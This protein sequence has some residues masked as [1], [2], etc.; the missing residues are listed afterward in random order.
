MAVILHEDHQD[1]SARRCSVAGPSITIERGTKQATSTTKEDERLGMQK[2]FLAMAIG[3][4][5]VFQ[6]GHALAGK[7]LDAVKTRGALICGVA[8]GGLAGFMMADSQG[9]WKGLDVDVC[10]A[11]AATIFGDS[12]KVK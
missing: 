11:V 6:S 4:A 2:S 9:K 7:N 3:L 8:A 1:R 10:R 5:T 12:E